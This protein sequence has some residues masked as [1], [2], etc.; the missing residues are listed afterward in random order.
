MTMEAMSILRALTATK[1]TYLVDNICKRIK[2]L[3]ELSLHKY[4]RVYVISWLSGYLNDNNQGN[5]QFKWFGRFSLPLSVFLSNF[6][7]RCCLVSSKHVLPVALHAI[8]G[9]VSK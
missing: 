1:F 6:S 5:F 8:H 4:V 9:S 2:G 3:P 7:I